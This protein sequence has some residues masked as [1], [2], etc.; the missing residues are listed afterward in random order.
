MDRLKILL[1][2]TGYNLTCLLAHLM[3]MCFI[4]L[5]FIGA[6]FWKHETFTRLSDKLYKDITEL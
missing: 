3:L 6:I 4:P 1:V 2:L 5:Y